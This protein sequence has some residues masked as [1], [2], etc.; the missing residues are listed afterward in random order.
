ME[1]KIR[2][3]THKTGNHT[4]SKLT[5][6]SL[7][8]FLLLKFFLFPCVIMWILFHSTR[9]SKCSK[10]A[11]TELTYCHKSHTWFLY[12]YYTY[13]YRHIWE[14]DWNLEEASARL[15]LAKRKYCFPLFIYLLIYIGRHGRKKKSVASPGLMFIFFSSPRLSNALTFCLKKFVSMNLMICHIFFCAAIIQL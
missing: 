3:C 8:V 1:T 5:L 10:I 2:H 4:N 12:L 13:A 9:R 14:L 15:S 6:H 7:N 11:F